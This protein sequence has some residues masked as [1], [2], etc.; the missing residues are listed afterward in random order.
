MT[1]T[2]IAAPYTT[3]FGKEIQSILENQC[4]HSQAIKELL[5]MVKLIT[6]YYEKEK[7]YRDDKELHR[8]YSFRHKTMNYVMVGY[9]NNMEKRREIHERNDWIYLGD[10][11]GTQRGTERP[12]LDQ[13][14]DEGFEPIPSSKEIF[15]I[16]EE[17]VNSMIKK[18][19]VGITKDLLQKDTQTS[20]S[21]DSAQS[22]T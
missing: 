21:L 19:W 16:S 22:S 3:H 2:K 11:Y 20:L 14:R 4:Q 15:P 7:K 10:K 6:D 18:K 13:L 9:S 5:E 17:I 12:F 8:V 1:K